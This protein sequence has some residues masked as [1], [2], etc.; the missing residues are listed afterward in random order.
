[1]V[2]N[3]ESKDIHR[4][5]SPACRHLKKTDVDS[6]HIGALFPVYLDGNKIWIQDRGNVRIRI[7]LPLHHVAPVAGVVTDR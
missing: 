5:A 7:G 4:P 3:L 6:V 1:M 2:S